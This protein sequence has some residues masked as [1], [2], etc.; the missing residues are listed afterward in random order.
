VPF[1]GLPHAIAHAYAQ[2]I[3]A[4]GR[5]PQFLVLSSFLATFVLT[6]V[7]THSIRREGRIG[8]NIRLRGVRV[9]HLVPG[10]LLLLVTGYL[11]IALGVRS[12][13]RLIAVMFGAGAALTLDEFALWLHLED[14]YWTE[15][16]RHSVHVVLAVAAVG[17]LILLGADFWL[18][19]ATAV[20]RA[21]A[22]L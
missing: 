16:G 19:V 15:R 11:S 3:V 17:S 20:G 22:R 18:D 12:D 21:F 6:R 7:V 9:H 2:H 10:I 14:V 1:G 4:A 13:S 5:E 8:R